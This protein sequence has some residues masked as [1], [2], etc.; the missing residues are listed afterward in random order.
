MYRQLWSWLTSLKKWHTDLHLAVADR[1]VYLCSAPS[2]HSWHSLQGTLSE[3][4]GR[5][6]RVSGHWLR[7]LLLMAGLSSFW[8]IPDCKL[9]A[10]LSLI[11]FLCKFL[12]IGIG[13][14]PH[15][16]LFTVTRAVSRII[17]IK[18]N[19]WKVVFSGGL[20]VYHISISSLI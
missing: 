2:W 19:L 15:Y 20:I 9:P 18:K 16:L 14:K 3:G 1:R 10:F 8:V 7:C 17:I 5:P 4:R 12:V 11:S 13:L 6:S